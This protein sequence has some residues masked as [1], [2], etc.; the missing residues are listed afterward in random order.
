MVIQRC[1]SSVFKQ[2]SSSQ[3]G[4]SLPRPLF[5]PLPLPGIPAVPPCRILRTPSAKKKQ[6]KTKN[7]EK[8]NYSISTPGRANNENWITGSM[9]QQKRAKRPDKYF[10][11]LPCVCTQAV[12]A[13]HGKRDEGRT[14]Q[15]P[16]K[17]KQSFQDFSKQQGAS[18]QPPAFQG[19][20]EPRG[21]SAQQ[22]TEDLQGILSDQSHREFSHQNADG[23][24]LGLN[25]VFRRFPIRDKRSTET[26]YIY[27]QW[28]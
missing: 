6:T 1:Y 19:R 4:T 21:A 20:R 15:K 13:V 9:L 8:A 2:P 22:N 16:S 27:F 24:G 11:S 7:K 14:M 28:C 5:A 17:M 3:N 23:D 18:A 12:P 26:V 10:G 25:K